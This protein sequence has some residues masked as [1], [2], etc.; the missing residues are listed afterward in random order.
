VENSKSFFIPHKYF[1]ALL[2]F[3]ATLCISLVAPANYN[4]LHLLGINKPKIKTVDA[5]VN[6]QQLFAEFETA[7]KA[8]LNQQLKKQSLLSAA[9]AKFGSKVIY[10]I[11][12]AGNKKVIALTFDDGPWKNTTQQ[13]LD[14]LKK[15]NVKATFFVV[16]SALK[17]NPQLGKQIIAQGHAIANHTW[18]HWYHFFNKQAASVEIDRTADLI[19]KT[20]GT[21]TTLFRPPGGILHNGL[22]SYAKSKDYTVVMWSADSIDYALPSPPVLVNRV[23]K[24]ATPGGIVLLHDGGGPRKNTVAALPKMISKLKDKGYRF[25]TIPELLEHE[26]KQKQTLTAQ[27]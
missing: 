23:V 27:N 5:Q 22:A 26:Q 1:I 17:N 19:Y 7:M 4:L 24:Q 9:P 8:T 18:N 15:E 21:K 16:G 10:E 3:T 14:I 13:T 25:V 2:I 12:P 11:K 20:T 6:N